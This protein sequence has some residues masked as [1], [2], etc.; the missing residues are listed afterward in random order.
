MRAS[1]AIAR[2]AREATGEVRYYVDEL[3]QRLTAL[4]QLF[5][6]APRREPGDHDDH[7]DDDDDGDDGDLRGHR[8][9]RVAK[10]PV[11]TPGSRDAL[12]AGIA[13]AL[14]LERALPGLLDPAAHAATVLISRI[15]G[16]H[17]EGLVRVANVFAS[18]SA[19]FE[20]G[21]HA[22]EAGDIGP[23][24]TGTAT[25]P[26]ETWRQFW[27]A[28]RDVAIALRGLF[29]REALAG[30]HGTWLVRAAAAEPDVVRVEVR[31]GASP[32]A[33]A[34]RAHLA[35][36]RELERVLDAGGALPPN[37]D[38]LLPVTRTLHYRPPLRLG[39][40]WYVELEDFATGWLDRGAVRDLSH[41]VRRA[42]HLAWSRRP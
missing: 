12:I 37:P 5:G 28:R 2:A 22:D 29:V 41:A 10:R 23:L 11:R 33:E 4:E 8:H 34:L 20:A 38:V 21:A 13:E 27:V 9:R 39:E 26:Y 15:G 14:L 7:D 40:P 25:V 30:D 3:D 35:A 32:P 36:R 18:Q 17:G 31:A 16:A 6:V 1:G 19:W 42:W 24:A